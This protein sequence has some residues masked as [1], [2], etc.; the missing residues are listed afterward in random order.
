MSINRRMDK[1]IM[2]YYSTT[3]RNEFQSVLVGWMSLEPVIQ[4]D[5]SQKEKNKYRIITHVCGIYKNGTD[6]PVCRAAMDSQTQRTDLWTWGRQAG[7]GGM[8]GE[9]NREIYTLTYVKQISSGNLLYD[10]GKSNQISVTTQRYGMGWEK[11]S[12]RRGHMYT[13]G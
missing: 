7:E 10:S 8:K 13:Y 11:G 2:K 12:R 5:I 9:S 6:E 1:E 3:D 4:T